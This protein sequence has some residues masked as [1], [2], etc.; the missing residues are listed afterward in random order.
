M[1]RLRSSC[2]SLRSVCWKRRVGG[3]AEG[4]HDYGPR[5]RGITARARGRTRLS[6]IRRSG[7]PRPIRPPGSTASSRWR[8]SAPRLRAIGLDA[9]QFPRRFD[10]GT[11]GSLSSRTALRTALRAGSRP[12]PASQLLLLPPQ[13]HP[14]ANPS[15]DCSGRH[16]RNVLEPK[17]QPG[18][19]PLHPNELGSTLPPLG[20]DASRRSGGGVLAARKRPA[21]MP[22]PHAPGRDLARAR[23]R[24]ALLV[25]LALLAGPR[26]PQDRALR[27]NRRAEVRRRADR[28]D[29]L[30][31]R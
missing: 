30:P 20:R 1:K 3:I 15:R 2:S 19:K 4:H 18:P 7:A 9:C 24:P 23:A 14:P 8:R 31:D 13:T 6:P 26:S 28:L 21:Q 25:L 29:L 5:A 10:S 11:A 16:V 17:C 22:L 27:Q 12:S